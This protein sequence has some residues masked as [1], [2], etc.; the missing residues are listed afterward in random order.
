M[1][2][3]KYLVF[4]FLVLLILILSYL[5]INKTDL[6]VN[7]KGIKDY[8]FL[9]PKSFIQDN[10]DKCPPGCVRGVCDDEENIGNC[11]YDYQCSYCAD[12]ETNRFYVDYNRQ[13]ILNTYNKNTNIKKN[14]DLNER[15]KEN[16]EYI[17]DLNNHIK[18]INS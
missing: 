14:K 17:N 7:Y 9:Y 1:N 10:I 16:N 11:I 15:I 4:V 12:E 5:I 8:N 2:I 6:I 3:I 13:D 18:D